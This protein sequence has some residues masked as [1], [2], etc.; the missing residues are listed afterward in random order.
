MGT[1]KT[2]SRVRTR[3]LRAH[4]LQRDPGTDVALSRP[5]GAGPQIAVLVEF[6]D[7]YRHQYGVPMM[8]PLVCHRF[9][10]D[11]MISGPLLDQ[12]YEQQVIDYGNAVDIRPST[13][14]GADG[15]KLCSTMR[16][17]PGSG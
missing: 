8:L 16:C 3:E 14:V 7:Q 15:E 2:V 5:S 13:A 17:A 1:E 11:F 12:E 9:T 10:A 6:I 4:A